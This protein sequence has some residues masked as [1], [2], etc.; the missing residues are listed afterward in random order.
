VE[1]LERDIQKTIIDYLRLH[2][3][4]CIRVNGGAL[5]KGS[6]YIRFTDTKGCADIIGCVNSQFFAIECKSSRGEQSRWQH[7]FQVA[8]EQSGGIYIL[9]RSLKD[10]EDML[11]FRKPKP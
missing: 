3:V 5:K 9:A 1:L 6:F 10:V 2:R 7:D 4:F 11:R 8:V